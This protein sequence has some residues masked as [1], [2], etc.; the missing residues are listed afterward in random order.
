VKLVRNLLIGLVAV[1]AVLAAVGWGVY[2]Y[3]IFTRLPEAGAPLAVAGPYD[4]VVEPAYGSP[5]HVIYR[6]A[7]L[8]AFPDVDTLPV[9]AWANGGCVADSAGYAAFLTTI[10]S[11]GV[12]V[13]TSAARE[14]QPLARATGD[15]LIAGVDWVEAE[16]AR[17]DSPLFGKIAAGEVAV[18][19]QSCGGGLTMEV[20]GD[21]RIDTIGLWN[22]G[23]GGGGAVARIHAPALYVNGGDR[24][25][26]ASAS[27]ADFEALDQVPAFYASR[28]GGGHLG[29][30]VH[31]GGGEFANVASA[32][33]LWRLKTDEAAG[34]MFAGPDCAL[35]A[36][37]NWTA[38][39]KGWSD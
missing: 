26:M 31:A 28:H 2:R 10:A 22:A 6:P 38:R 24:D 14:G 32:W 37:P 25:L 18:M 20:A 21:P 13:V 16:N 15:V 35:C 1:A 3:V 30:L 9:L 34:A 11:H 5:D 33:L 29:T 39:A 36:D 19:G 8:D 17:S 4:V 7:S 23:T 12:L 27:Q